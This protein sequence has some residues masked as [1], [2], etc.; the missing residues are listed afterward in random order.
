MI[1][2]YRISKVKVR[3]LGKYGHEGRCMEA[4]KETWWVSLWEETKHR[5]TRKRPC[6]DRGLESYIDTPRNTR[7]F[8]KS[9]EAR[10]RKEKIP[11]K[12]QWKDGPTSTMIL[13]F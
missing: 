1:T 11:Y 13:D 4:P 3:S 7:Y 12:L 6:E 8:C 10:K 5:D 9:S 2:K